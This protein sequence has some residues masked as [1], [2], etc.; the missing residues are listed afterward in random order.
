MRVLIHSSDQNFVS[1]LDFSHSHRCVV[2]PDY[3]FNLHF[4]DDICCVAS[5][6]ILSSHLYMFFGEV[7]VKVFGPFKNQ[8]VYY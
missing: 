7:S 2:I 4:P 1:V 8:V 5:F 6:N 3:Y